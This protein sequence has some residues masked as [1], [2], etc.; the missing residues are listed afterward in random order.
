[1]IRSETIPQ[2]LTQGKDRSVNITEATKIACEEPTLIEALSWIAVWESE[3]AIAQAK[4]FFETGESTA[5]DGKGWGTCFRVCFQAV[6]K[7]YPS[8]VSQEQC[9]KGA[10][11]LLNKTSMRLSG[12]SPIKPHDEIDDEI[13]DFL[14]PNT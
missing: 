9:L 14:D 8:V 3:R 7:A 11:D 10:M 13:R 1:M 12:G 5:S 6:M 2:T 4:K